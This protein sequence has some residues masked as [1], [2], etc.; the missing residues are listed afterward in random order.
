MSM[1]KQVI[2][3]NWGTK[4]GPAYINR[5]YG[6]VSRNITPPFSFTCFT[7]NRT[8]IRPEVQCEDLPPINAVM[9]TGTLGI[10][11]K[12]RLWGPKLGALTGPVLFLDLDLVVTGSLDPFFDYGAPGDVILSRNPARPLEKLGQTSVFR[13]PVG[14]L[15]PL[16]QRFEAD[17]QGVADEYRFEQRFVTRNA[18]GGISLF[19]AP[20]VRHFRRECR[21]PFPL[22]YVLPPRLPKD[23]RIVIFPGSL[24]PYHAIEGRY[25][26]GS[27]RETALAHLGRTFGPGRTEGV[28]AHLRHFILPTKWVEEHWRP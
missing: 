17:P 21:Q 20:W 9:P 7:D 11:P 12:S 14:A 16:Q 27:P 6:M 3:I 19:P 24:E 15:L 18:P 25:D 4:Y 8:G 5:L 13:F 28:W 1:T 23:A 2:C 10:W 22:N 26:E